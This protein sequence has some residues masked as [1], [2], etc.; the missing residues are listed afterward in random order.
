MTLAAL[1]LTPAVLTGANDVDTLLA[2]GPV[3][4]V[5]TDPAGK[6]AAAIGQVEV[7]APLAVVWSAV[8]SFARYKEFVP[9]V[10]ESRVEGVLAEPR[11]AF[12]IESPGINT[13]YVAQY[14]I[15]REGHS[16]DGRQV[17]GDLEGSTW[18]WELSAL[19]PSRT[20]LRHYSRARNLSRVVAAFEDAAQTM[21]TGINVAGVITV[22]RAMKRRCEQ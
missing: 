12:E 15:D 14:R 3:V 19:G 2:R 16:V 22:L 8:T 13:R 17:S 20:R 9:K 1:L 21:T 18:R 6:F 10:V 7:D 11:V 4:A 5:S